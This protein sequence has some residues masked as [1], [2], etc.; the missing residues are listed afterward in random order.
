MQLG[1]QGFVAPDDDTDARSGSRTAGDCESIWRFSTDR[2]DAPKLVRIQTARSTPF[3]LPTTTPPPT[4][5][6]AMRRSPICLLG[7]LLLSLL[8]AN[9]LNAQEKS[10]GST[11]SRAPNSWVAHTRTASRDTSPK[12]AAN[13]YTNLENDLNE[14]AGDPSP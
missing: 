9:P 1:N 5:S 13:G 12:A 4:W 10:D 2:R 8:V 11:T 6:H 3:A 7:A 14:L